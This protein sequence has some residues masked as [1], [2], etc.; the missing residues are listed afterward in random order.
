MI[1]SP[2]IMTIR[3]RMTVGKSGDPVASKSL[4]HLFHKIKGQLDEAIQLENGRLT[5]FE[6]EGL[7]KFFVVSFL[8]T[9]ISHCPGLLIDLQILTATA[10]ALFAEENS[11]IAV[12]EVASCF[13]LSCVVMVG[14]NGVQN[15]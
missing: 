12:I 8:P 7:A 3:E 15:V 13:I 5:H 11:D 9:R 6:V 4:N 2:H 1:C 14:S 10:F